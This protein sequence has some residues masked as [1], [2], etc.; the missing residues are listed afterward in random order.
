MPQD[1][2]EIQY[3]IMMEAK[4][5]C[6]PPDKNCYE[7]GEP[8]DT[9][10]PEEDEYEARL[11]EIG[12][13]IYPDG[14]PMDDYELEVKPDVEEKCELCN[15]S[16]ATPCYYNY[17]N[18]ECEGDL[19]DKHIC[20]HANDDEDIGCKNC[21]WECGMV[22]SHM[23]F[24]YFNGGCKQMNNIYEFKISEETGEPVFMYKNKESSV[25]QPNNCWTE[26]NSEYF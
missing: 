5:E 22:A 17:D 14:T 13:T 7:D 18:Q 9:S 24:A 2:E 26:V 3:E 19:C 20:L 23:D 12:N 1:P 6:F 15:Q 8:Y 16:P 25:Y 4:C 10:C 21:R 11:N